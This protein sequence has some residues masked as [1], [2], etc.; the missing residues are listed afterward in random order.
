MEVSLELKFT[1]KDT[2]NIMMLALAGCTEFL[3]HP[4]LCELV[5]DEWEHRPNHHDRRDSSWY[6][7]A[8]LVH[9]LAFNGYS[10]ILD[11][12]QYLKVKNKYGKTPLHLL[13][14]HMIP[15]YYRRDEGITL[16]PEN[17][18]VLDRVLKIEGLCEMKAEGD[19]EVTPLHY[20]GELGYIDMIDYPGV[21]KI[22]SPEW[23]CHGT[24]MTH[25]YRNAT[26]GLNRL[27]K[28]PDLMTEYQCH[29]SPLEALARNKMIRPTV[30][31]LRRYKFKMKKNWHSSK[32]LDGSVVQDMLS[33]PKSIRFMIY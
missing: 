8:T 1:E 11:Y 2:P 21:E 27:L 30:K 25:L 4:E 22:E 26:D 23:N 10:E 3:K 15:E 12:P 20:I 32:K 14:Q 24:P 31:I 17:I 9:A 13:L 19:N 7:E 28:H 33:I 5:N 29:G 16:T 18:K 6:K